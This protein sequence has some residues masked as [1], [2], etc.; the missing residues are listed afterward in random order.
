[1]N[2]KELFTR[3]WQIKLLSLIIA[4]MIWYFITSNL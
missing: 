3:N 1:M 2:I 4:L